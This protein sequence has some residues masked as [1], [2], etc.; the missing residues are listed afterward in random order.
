MKKILELMLNRVRAAYLEMPG[1]RLTLQ[2][3]QRLC[4]V[5]REM[6]Q[7]VLDALVEA[8]FLCAKT[9]GTYARVSDGAD[10]SRVHRRTDRRGRRTS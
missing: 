5:E 3:T 10:N 6:C 2:Q 7:V 9:D 8:D 1:L 4:G